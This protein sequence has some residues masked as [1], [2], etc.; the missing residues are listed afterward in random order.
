[1]IKIKC[2]YCGFEREFDGATELPWNLEEPQEHECEKCGKTF[3]IEAE[4]EFIGH[5]VSGI[6]QDCREH[7]ED[8]YCG[9][10]HN[11]EAEHRP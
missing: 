5:K 9:G 10:E 8:C 2:P 11:K 3:E 1:M 4:Y 6:C 7:L